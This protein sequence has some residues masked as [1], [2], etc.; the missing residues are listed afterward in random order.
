[1]TTQVCDVRL[2]P[3]VEV[4]RWIEIKGLHRWFSLILFSVDVVLHR[5]LEDGIT[6]TLG[7]HFNSSPSFWD[8]RRKKKWN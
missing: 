8:L 1:M 5:H 2:I 6:S 7:L 4:G 3:S